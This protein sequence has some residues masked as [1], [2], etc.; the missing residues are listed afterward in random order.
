MIDG[1]YFSDIS[2]SCEI[3]FFC[4]RAKNINMLPIMLWWIRSRSNGLVNL[5]WYLKNSLSNTLDCPFGP[6]KDLQ[7]PESSQNLLWP[8]ATMLC[9]E[10]RISTD[11]NILSVELIPKSFTDIYHIFLYITPPKLFRIQKMPI[12]IITLHM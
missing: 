6:A 1:N 2:M 8:M 11:W 9:C 7:R 3:I 4:R 12:N 10:R 5:L